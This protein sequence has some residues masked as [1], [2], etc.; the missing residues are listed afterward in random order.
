MSQSLPLPAST[1]GYSTIIQML[2]SAAPTAPDDGKSGFFYKKASND[3]L[4]WKTLGAG[5]VN[6]V[7]A[8][9]SLLS[10]GTSTDIF[11]GT[12]ITAP[13]CTKA[14]T[15][16]L[17]ALG[18]A[19]T[20][21]AITAFGAYALSSLPDDTFSAGFTA[22]GYKA[23]SS[24][25]S[26]TTSTIIGYNCC[27]LMPFTTNDVFVGADIAYTSTVASGGDN[28]AIGHGCYVANT[29]SGGGN[30]AIGSNTLAAV[31]TATNN[32]CVGL[33]AGQGMISGIN[34]ILIGVL[35]GFQ[36][37]TAIN[38][39]AVGGNTLTSNISTTGLVA[40]GNSALSN[41]TGATNM[42]LGYQAGSV[43]TTGSNN[44]AIGANAN[45]VN[46]SSSNNIIIGNSS[47]CTASNQLRIGFGAAQAS[48]QTSCYIDGIYGQNTTVGIATYID[49]TGKLGT[50]SSSKRYKHD[51]LDIPSATIENLFNLRPVSFIYN[52]DKTNTRTYG[53]IAEEVRDIM[54]DIV[55]YKKDSSTNEYIKDTDDKNMVETVQYHLLVPLLIGAI[56]NLKQEIT[57]LK[58]MMMK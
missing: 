24:I 49:S 15:N 39:V 23:G 4:F 21:G 26:G 19:T 18:S 38:C 13:S 28:I 29:F 25:T 32:I 5:E 8:G 57:S 33:N 56:K 22:L 43:I 35:S 20:N 55:V 27:P 54:D 30:I 6:L 50:V 1:K 58:S 51:I 47:R 14:G 17:S 52:E 11:D 3:G 12:P 53:L 16:A 42:G 31:T 45:T 40:V 46:G 9:G 7:S 37:D 41:A 2:D 34:N 36:I 10:F 44:I 48:I